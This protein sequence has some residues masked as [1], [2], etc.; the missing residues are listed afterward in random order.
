MIPSAN[1]VEELNSERRWWRAVEIQRHLRLTT[2]QVSRLDTLFERELPQR[3]QRHRQIQNMDRHLA[4]VIERD[5]GDDHHVAHLSQQVEA[6]RAT[7]NIRRTLM[8]FAMYQTLTQEQRTL[9][10][11]MHRSSRGAPRLEPSYP[12]SGSR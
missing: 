2:A 11:H 8:L 9:L 6:L 7:Q 5:N 3:I 12:G 10:A 1:R 4:Y